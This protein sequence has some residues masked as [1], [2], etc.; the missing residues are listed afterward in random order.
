[1]NKKDQYR[2]HNWRQYNQS[3]KNRGNINLWLSEEVLK[4]WVVQPL[5]HQ[6]KGRPMVYSNQAMLA[7][8]SIRAVL[9]L[10]LRAVEGY[11]VSLFKIM[12]LELAV[13]CYTQVC[14][15]SQKLGKELQKLLKTASNKKVTDVVID[16]TGVKVYGEGEWKVRQHKKD[17]R[18]VWCKLH[19][20]VD[21]ASHEV[22]AAE[23]TRNNVHDSCVFD[24]LLRPLKKGI[25]K[26]Y[27]DGA[28][29]AK[30][31]YQHSADH[32]AMLVVPPRKNS[33]VPRKM[34]ED[35][36]MPRYEACVRIEYL[37]QRLGDVEAARKA[38]KKEIG[39]HRRSLA[40]TAMFR[41]K[42]IFGDKMRSRNFK[43]QEAE[44]LV[45]VLVLNKL[46]ELGMPVSA[47]VIS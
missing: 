37:R 13:P 30:G 4:N 22:V 20:A 41:F 7:L 8:L 14:R 19:L 39:Y 6:K 3:L 18:R 24:K 11:A 10:P 23:V 32:K 17:K 12:K 44:A 16:S 9:N 31:C 38:W 43:N 45:K 5:S 36:L 29:D 35:Y 42:R 28:Y 47:K 26:V 15:G 1:M 2:I 40:E 34:P 46:T 21:P 27:A 33:R 25:R